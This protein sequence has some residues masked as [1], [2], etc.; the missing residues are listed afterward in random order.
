[1]VTYA[2]TNIVWL[3]AAPTAFA[4]MG[5]RYYLFF[6]IFTAIGAVVVWFTFPDTLNMPLEEIAKL[7]GDDDLVVAYQ[8]HDSSDGGDERKEARA[9]MVERSS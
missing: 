6:I 8:S 1:V 3:Q 2:A 5:W 9:E 4:S 7:F